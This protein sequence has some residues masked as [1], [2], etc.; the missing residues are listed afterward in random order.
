MII[1]TDHDVGIFSVTPYDRQQQVND[2]NLF[3]SD[4]NFSDYP[5]VL[6]GDFNTIGLPLSP[7]RMNALDE[8]FQL[9]Y[10]LETVGMCSLP[11]STK[12]LNTFRKFMISRPLDHIFLHGLHCIRWGT[13]KGYFGS[14]HRPLWMVAVIDRTPNV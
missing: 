8:I 4:S 12:P 2:L 9:K 14:D 1:N 5:M 6:L 3:I 11:E 10:S 7:F 13:T